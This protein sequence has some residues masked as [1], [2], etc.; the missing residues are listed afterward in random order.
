M[1]LKSFELVENALAVIT[2]ADAR[3]SRRLAAAAAKWRGA[4]RARASP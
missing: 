1:R 4:S 3:R 2:V